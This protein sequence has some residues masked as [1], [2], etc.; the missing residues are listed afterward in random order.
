MS[1]NYVEKLQVQ[2]NK[3]FW[4]EQVDIKSTDLS[5]LSYATIREE[6]TVFTNQILA[7]T[8]IHTPY[9]ANSPNTNVSYFENSN[10]MFSPQDIKLLVISYSI[11]QPIDL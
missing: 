10:N 3:P 11:N 9:A 2:V 4:A 7:S 5:I 6:E 8:T 1:I